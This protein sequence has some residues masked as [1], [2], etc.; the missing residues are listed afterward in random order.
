MRER[1]SQKELIL[2]TRGSPLAL[3]Q[4]Q[5]ATMLLEKH[6]YLTKTQSFVTTG[7]KILDK[8]LSSLVE[9]KI[10]SKPTVGKGFFIKEVEEALLKK[11]A[12]IAVHSFKDFPVEHG[13]EFFIP[14]LL[15][16]E[17]CRD[18]LL[19]SSELFEF[20]EKKKSLSSL[21][22]FE[23]FEIL[24]PYFYNNQKSCL[25]TASLRRELLLK[26]YLPGAQIKFLRGNILTRINKLNEGGYSA[27][28]L[29]EAGLKRLD[30]LERCYN[31]P[32]DP[33]VF[34]PAPAQGV[35]ALETLS[36]NNRLIQNLSLLN[37]KDTLKS[38]SIERLALKVLNGGCHSAISLYYLNK[39]LHI[40]SG[41]SHE[42]LEAKIE[43][44]KEHDEI[45]EECYETNKSFTS[46]F[47]SLSKSSLSFYLK[48]EFLSHGFEKIFPILK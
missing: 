5:L 40:A 4:A 37:H 46:L 42:F 30:L 47:N 19:L 29:A 10:S 25:G 23:L 45:F 6:G 24:A 22:I 31:Y 12:Q 14:S 38:S 28:L 21:G 15:P 11:H 16:R 44:K 17:S 35:I 18:V 7:D 43:I 27:I 9:E 36:E 34:I 20:V 1:N 8:K 26:K 39:V 13:S 2:A 48:K 32:L 3:K 41:N 33:K